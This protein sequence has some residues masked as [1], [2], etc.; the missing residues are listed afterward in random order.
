M[1]TRMMRLKVFGQCWHPKCWT[2]SYRGSNECAWAQFLLRPG[3][4]WSK[5]PWTTSSKP[6][7]SLGQDMIMSLALSLGVMWTRQIKRMSLTLMVPSS[8][9]RG[10]DGQR[11]WPW[12]HHFRTQVRC[13]IQGRGKKKTVK[14]RPLPNSKIPSFAREF[15]QLT[16]QEVSEEPDINIAVQNFHKFIVSISLKHFPEK[17]W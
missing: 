16:W 17:I 3:P 4:H 13:Q 6:Y 10:Q 2:I 9:G 1:L 12:H 15:H 14:L 7:T 8:S 11:L 5:E